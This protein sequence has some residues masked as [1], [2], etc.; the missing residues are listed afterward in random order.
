MP[1]T[2]TLTMTGD[3]DKRHGPYIAS[4][5]QGVI[6][7][8]I[9]PM[10]AGFLHESRIHPYSQYV[11][12]KDGKI[13]W[14]ISTLTKEAEEAMLGPLMDESFSELELEHRQETLRIEGRT[15]KA[16][17]YEELIEGYYLGDCSRNI[18]IQILTP[19]A[20]KQ[21]GKYCIIPSTR[22]IFQSLMM[23]F[24]ACSPDSSIF[25][26]ELLQEFESLTEII[27]YRLHTVRFSLEGVRI[28]SFSGNLTIHVNG[29]KQMANVAWM[30]A[31]FGEFSGVG[32]KTGLGMGAITL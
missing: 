15:A 11:E 32:I 17:S 16:L 22:L 27:S 5:L 12:E 13:L 4:M 8:K 2:L 18:P 20:F 29:P 24:D 30:L 1:K 19:M 3:A 6:M 7:E 23:R 25:T 14:H 28:P 26:E 31:K 21:G 10:Y 9:D